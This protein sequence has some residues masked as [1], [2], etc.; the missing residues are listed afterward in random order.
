MKV[1][2]CTKNQLKVG[3]VDLP[4]F[5]GWLPDALKIENTIYRR[6]N[7]TTQYEEV[8]IMWTVEPQ[9]VRMMF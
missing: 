2:I 5:E 6:V 9:D 4:D 3:T 1:E 8:G 7:Q